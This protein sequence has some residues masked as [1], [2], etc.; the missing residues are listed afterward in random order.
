MS[1][2]QRP[3]AR[4]AKTFEDRTLRWLMRTLGTPLDVAGVH[5]IRDVQ[6]GRYG[7]NKAEALVRGNLPEQCACLSSEPGADNDETALA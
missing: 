2:F 6:K 7:D 5:R 3:V 4:W 1:V